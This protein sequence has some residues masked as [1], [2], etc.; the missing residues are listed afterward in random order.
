MAFYSA[1]SHWLKLDLKGHGK[2]IYTTRWTPTGPGSANASKPLWLCTASF[3]GTVKV[4]SSEN[5][6]VIHT[7]RRQQQP[8][9]SISPNPT[10]E[11]IAT[12]SLGGFVAIFSLV[13][14]SLIREIKGNGDTFDVS[15]SHDGSLMSCCFSSG[16]LHVFDVRQQG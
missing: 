11:F 6:D 15:W 5:G 12:G 1:V 14:G 10:G 13:D 7:L 16:T 2:E 8:V 9:Y 3:D 4:W